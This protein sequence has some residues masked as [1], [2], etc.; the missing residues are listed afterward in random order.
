LTYVKIRFATIY[1]KGNRVLLTKL[2]KDKGLS[3]A[4]LARLAAIDQSQMSLIE[5]GRFK[6]YEKQ[7]NRLAKA[8]EVTDPH[9]LLLPAE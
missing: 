7:L 5:S 2:R 9:S 1:P 3:K 4:A 8:L 6:P